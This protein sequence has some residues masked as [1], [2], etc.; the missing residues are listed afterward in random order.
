MPVVRTG[1]A[2]A[3]IGDTAQSLAAPDQDPDE[4]QIHTGFGPGE[5]SACGCRDVALSVGHE[6]RIG[7]ALQ[8]SREMTQLC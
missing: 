4:L 2:K 8:R 7:L 1:D 5:D 6:H 3:H